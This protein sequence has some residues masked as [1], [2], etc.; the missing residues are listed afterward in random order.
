MP[1]FRKE[2][3]VQ[4]AEAH[5][6]LL[7]GPPVERGSAIPVCARRIVAIAFSRSYY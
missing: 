1:F 2:F 6:G 7:C 5:K 4:N 3:L